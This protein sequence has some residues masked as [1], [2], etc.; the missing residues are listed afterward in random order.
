MLKS[1]DRELTNIS[2]TNK[3]FQ[4]IYPE[5]LDLAKKLSY[6]WD[7][8]MSDES[9]PGVVLLKLAALIADKNNYNID[10]NILELFPLS[11]TQESNARQLYE[12]LGYTMRYYQ[13]A[14]TTIQ[15]TITNPPIP[16]DTQC[17][18][19]GIVNPPKEQDAWKWKKDHE[20]IYTI[21]KFTMIS[22]SENSVVY[23]I[24]EDTV[25][26]S[27]SITVSSP[28]LEG[29]ATQYRINGN[30]LITSADLDY[31][32][33][34]YF[35]ES[36][37]SEN[38]IFISSKDDPNAQW[39][40]V[41]NLYIQPL[42]TLCYKFGLNESGN[43][44]Y[45][46]FP[47]DI[48]T[49]ISS[50][51]NIT[52]LRSMGLEGNIGKN[53]LTQFY[54]DI[55]VKA[56]LKKST[57]ETQFT[58]TNDN[59]YIV[60]STFATDGLNP[61]TIDE[62]Y[63]N[64][65]KV[66]NTFN[67]LVS[68]TDY[69]NFM[70][71]QGKV[72]NGYVCDRSDDIQT[73]YKL[74]NTNNNNNLSVYNNTSVVENVET[75]DDALLNAFNLKIYALSYVDTINTGPEFLQSF[76]PLSYEQSTVSDMYELHNYQTGWGE[77][78]TLSHD[79]LDPLPYKIMMIKNK[80]PLDITII[81]QYKVTDLQSNEIKNSIR[82]ALYKALN[83]RE[84]DFGEAIPYNI[85]YDI[86]S[87]SDSR[88]KGVILQN[89]NYETYAIYKEPDTETTDTQ[90]VKRILSGEIKELRIDSNSNIPYPDLQSPDTDDT[91]SEDYQEYQK[92]HKLNE[93]WQEFRDEVFIRS[94][95]SGKTQLLI[96][97]DT[98]EHTLYETNSNEAKDIYKVTTDTAITISWPEK[99]NDEY[100]KP[101]S[102]TSTNPAETNS[103]LLTN[104]NI[105]FTA[106]NLIDDLPYST[107]VKYLYNLDNA[108]EPNTDYTLQGDECIYFFWVPDDTTTTY[109]FR[110]Y[111]AGTRI[112]TF[113][114]TFELPQIQPGYT[115]INDNAIKDEKSI[116][117]DFLV[118]LESH[119]K[120]TTIYTYDNEKLGCIEGTLSDN[121]KTPLGNGWNEFIKSL[122][123]S[124]Y[125]LTGTSQITTK[126]VNKV[127]I[128]ND[129]GTGINRI[130]WILN[131]KTE[132]QKYR[133][134][135]SYSYTSEQT[136]SINNEQWPKQ[137]YILQNG[138]YLIY[139]NEA[140]TQLNTLSSGTIITRTLDSTYE[141]T[142]GFL[143]EWEVVAISYDEF[144]SDPFV[145]LSD[146]W[147]D[148]QNSI[149]VYATEQQ[150]YQVGPG[151]KIRL[152]PIGDYNP[153]QSITFHNDYTTF[154]NFKG[155]SEDLDLDDSKLCNYKISLIDTTNNIN[156]MTTLPVRRLSE[157]GWSAKT[158]LNINSGPNSPQVVKGHQQIKFYKNNESTASLTLGI[159]DNPDSTGI[160]SDTYFITD[161]DLS[162]TGGIGVDTTILDL[163]TSQIIPLHVYSFNQLDPVTDSLYNYTPNSA[164]RN[165]ELKVGQKVD[166]APTIEIDLSLPKGQYL[167]PMSVE[168]LGMKASINFKYEEQG[169][170][171][172]VPLTLLNRNTT[173]V[174]IIADLEEP[175]VKYELGSYLLSLD[176]TNTNSN[177]VTGSLILKIITDT[178]EE[179]SKINTSLIK[180]SC[181]YKYT[182]HD[183]IK[184]RYEELL[185]KVNT[186]NLDYVFS[187]TYQ[188]PQSQLIEDPLNSVSFL[189]SGHP[190]NKFTICEWNISDTKNNKLIIET[191]IK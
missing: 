142:I 185:N 153:N 166:V 184:D 95:V 24:T 50:G 94:V 129:E 172:T 28:A 63:R 183:Y 120:D 80:Y 21:P 87:N 125:V 126:K 103:S 57:S 60:N 14:S 133:L 40:R 54:N 26:S 131:N 49:I 130:Y 10:K 115:Y 73:S 81:P 162:L 36:D 68:T 170:T 58:L 181:P 56:H 27:N 2:Y 149:D 89:I 135:D 140:Q 174:T 190:Y 154:T 165:L 99:V 76:R 98:F 22:D 136:S 145:T 158:L 67:T 38:G 33:R 79:F 37:I 42:G 139:A 84:I 93:L 110:K 134:F 176:L 179:D 97:D 109:T 3:D 156:T 143:P 155:E 23:T 175:S 124:D 17:S 74:L 53:K 13:S 11:V 5:L 82:T 112:N 44:C 77:L 117:D 173:S 128:N 168:N 29:V 46:E 16:D 132:D 161:R 12:Q 138:E 122:A 15:F 31:N 25:V 123:G 167:I 7:P 111:T 100:T 104:E 91:S 90:G 159:Q 65:Q 114:S 108:I 119:I 105:V 189:N 182:P 88:I 30:D 75:P 188:V 41:D 150:W 148:I 9:D 152:D 45:L 39:N 51:I 151:Y 61:E 62:A 187:Y 72:S 116:A 171:E 32:R 127:H 85:V 106:V 169:V 4:T 101:D 107:Y 146:K 78:K 160:D 1:T 59:I 86:I 178:P 191:H 8:S 66:K 186:Y 34:L 18:Q 163:E 121:I 137:S 147:Y 55:T 71:S 113:S 43:A 47:S 83:S 141:S 177:I 157:Y 180:L 92:K 19:L 96:A 64:Y 69:S 102:V 35:N 144:L 118:N 52:Y 48:D 164:T 20:M 70:I 6:K